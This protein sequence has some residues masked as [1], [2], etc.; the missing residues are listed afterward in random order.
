MNV[1]RRLLSRSLEAVISVG[2]YFLTLFDP[3]AMPHPHPPAMP[4]EPIALSLFPYHPECVTS[5]PP[6]QVEREI[7]SALGDLGS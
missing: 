3:V 4:A 5:R 6:T 2:P 7:W 1:V